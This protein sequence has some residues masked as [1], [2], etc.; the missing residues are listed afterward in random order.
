MVEQLI[1]NEKVAGSTPATGTKSLS[2]C[3]RNSHKTN[4][5]QLVKARRSQLSIETL[6]E[7]Q[8]GLPIK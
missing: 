5:N 7:F 8:R 3:I 4:S 2:D 6:S 1:C